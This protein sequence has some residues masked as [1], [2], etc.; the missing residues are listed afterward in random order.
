MD[1]SHN[2]EACEFFANENDKLFVVLIQ[3]WN[4]LCDLMTVLKHPF[5]TTCYLQTPKLTLSDMYGRWLKL[6]EVELKR[7]INT[8]VGSQAKFSEML[9]KSLE[10]RKQMILNHPLVFSS[11]YLDPRYRHFLSD[12]QLRIAKETLF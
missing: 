5:D 4:V 7:L 9:Y 11:V 3:K 1:L 8:G 12:N 6:S 2:K 10:N